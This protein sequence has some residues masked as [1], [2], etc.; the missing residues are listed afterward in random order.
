VLQWYS[1][2]GLV[3]AIQADTAVRIKR[4]IDQWWVQQ[5]LRAYT[6]W[7]EYELAE[8]AWESEGGAHV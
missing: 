7:D 2:D 5:F 4:N 6:E 8:Q 1:Q 3:D